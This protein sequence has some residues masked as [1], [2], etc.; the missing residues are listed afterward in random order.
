MEQ[1]SVG[2]AP[3]AG[4]PIVVVVHGLWMP[5]RG[6]TLLLRRR[7]EAAGFHTLAFAYPSV[8]AGLDENTERLAE[9]V[10]ERPEQRIDFVGHSLGGVITVRML[11]HYPLGPR[12]GRVVCLGSPL[13]ACR[14]GALLLK[15]RWGSALAGRSITDLV[16]AGGLGCWQGACELGILAGDFA[17]GFGRLL[18]GL[19]LPNDGT[20]TVEETRLPGAD[21]HRVLHVTH[22]G[23]LASRQ[24]AA[25]TACF[26]RTGRFRAQEPASE[27]SS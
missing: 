9:W 11:Q 15:H 18:R 8:T 4:F 21:A 20:V 14:G 26:L 16:Q 13:T 2:A 10:V 27:A 22:L 24:V 19:P 25:E 17:L 12:L 3:D 7:L 23:L 5:A 6:S 1:N